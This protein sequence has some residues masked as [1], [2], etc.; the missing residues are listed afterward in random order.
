MGFY[1]LLIMLPFYIFKEFA[2]KLVFISIIQRWWDLYALIFIPQNKRRKKW[3]CCRGSHV[4]SVGAQSLR[5]LPH[6]CLITLSKPGALYSVA[7]PCVV[8]DG[9]FIIILAVSR[10]HS[11][12]DKTLPLFNAPWA[13]NELRNTTT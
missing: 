2:V 10:A 5:S 8:L 9:E 11:E 7:A 3:G 13:E 12:L 6:V 1:F 4:P